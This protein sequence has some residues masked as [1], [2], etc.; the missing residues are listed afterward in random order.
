[1]ARRAA[2]GA[3]RRGRAR[4]RGG[5]R[6]I[7]AV[8]FDVGETLL[9]EA[10]AWAALARAAGIE[11]HVMWAGLGAAIARGDDHPRVYELLDI[12]RPAGGTLGW[13]DRD[14]YPDARPALERLRAAGYFV[15]VAGNVGWD[16]EPFL[17]DSRVHVDFVATSFTLGVEKPSPEFFGR[18]IA[19]A[20]VPAGEVAYV[21]DRIDND[22]APAAAAGMLP[23]H[24][25]RGPWGYLQNGAAPN[26]VRISSL[27]E[28][29][30][31]FGG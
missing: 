30:A 7:R 19:A 13:E 31:A 2:G 22:V 10:R 4:A 15:G 1:V 24:I 25:R 23:V 6:L 20:G 8:F 27:D 18:L 29:P 5:R 21:G 16:L 28:L 3:D 17:A 14:F 12:E 26:H 11:P 9:N